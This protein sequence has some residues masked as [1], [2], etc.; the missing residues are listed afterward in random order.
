MK[1]ISPGTVTVGVMAVLFGLVSAYAARHY[2][3]QNPTTPVVA[4]EATA[5]IVVPNV[6]LPQYA[7]IR[8]RD[9]KVVR[10]PLEQ[11]PEGAVRSK[12]QA[13]FRRVK[14]TVM[15]D[16][17]ILEKHL[18]AIGESPRLSDQLSPGYRA[19]TL[20]VDV[21]SAINGM[22]QPGSHV[23]IALTATNDRPEIGGLATV[24][25]LRDVKILAT[26]ISQFPASEDR[27]RRLSN[28]TVAV[29]PEDANKLILAQRY[30]SLSVTLRSP[31]DEGAV[32]SSDDNNLVNPLD[33][34][35]LS[36]LLPI[37]QPVPMVTRTMEIWR[38]GKL[39][40]VQFT[41]PAIQ[42]SLNATAVAEGRE[43][44]AFIPVSSQNATGTS[45]QS[46]PGATE[47]CDS[48]DKKKAERAAKAAGSTAQ[49]RAV[50]Q[51]TIAP[52]QSYGGRPAGSMVS[53]QVEAEQT[54]STTN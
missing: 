8:D 35:G 20:P 9:V 4:E 18:Y 12:S 27:P 46:V 11:L 19:V 53:I 54:G 5:T 24:T 45:V 37:P 47:E 51:P 32:A 3:A 36:D 26:S 31:L 10:I 48:C 34:L 14:S 39:Q 22:I 42:E 52:P 44:N 23:D 50:D 28:I 21:N 38:G 49:N 33:L 7:S 6:N 25:L 13:L 2:F 15:A 29:T 41:A 1:R 40:Q 30:G 43:P 16:Q 17:P